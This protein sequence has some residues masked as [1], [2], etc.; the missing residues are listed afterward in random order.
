MQNAGYAG[1]RF[2][3]RGKAGIYLDAVCVWS[4]WSFQTT[5]LSTA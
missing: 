4:L 2:V 5:A 1:R 3:L